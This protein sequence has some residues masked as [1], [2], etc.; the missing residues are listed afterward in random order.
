MWK[1]ISQSNLFLNTYKKKKYFDITVNNY[2]KNGSQSLSLW[3]FM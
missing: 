2:D 3:F 1:I